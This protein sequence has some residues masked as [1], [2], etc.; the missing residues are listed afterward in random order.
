MLLSSIL[1]C[2]IQ[3]YLQCGIAQIDIVYNKYVYL[4]CFTMKT[5]I[6]LPFDNYCKF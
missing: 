5:S 3:S 6:K 2:G 4:Q 1:Q